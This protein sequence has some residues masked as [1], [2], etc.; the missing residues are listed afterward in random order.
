M[1]MRD[2][3]LQRGRELCWHPE[4]MRARFE[5]WVEGLTGDWNI[6]RQRS[7]GCRSRSGTGSTTPARRSRG[8]AHRRAR[9]AAGRPLDRRPTGW[10]ESQRG[11]PG[12]FVGDADIMD[13]WATSS[14]SPQ[15]AGGWID[16][17]DL[18]GRVFPMDLRPQAHDII[19]TWLFTTIVRAE[20][21]QQ[22]LPWQHAAISGWIL[23]PDRKKLSKSKGNA[24][25]VPSEPLEHYGTDAVRYWAAS[26]RLGVDTAYDE[27]Q[28]KVGRRLAIKMLNVSRFVLSLSEEPSPSQPG[29]GSPGVVSEA[30]D[31]ALLASLA[32]VVTEATQAFERF[33]HSRSLELLEGFFW[34]Y[35]DDYVE[36]V[37]AR[38]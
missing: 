36:L 5:S 13:T 10:D 2:R 31:A 14:L 18:F 11:R 12:G 22:Q 21:E 30:L 16:D 38:A 28:M 3:L 29:A 15:I 24:A 20:L 26:A 34:S 27:Q 4:F 37:K 17:P 23:D 19:R 35:C 33:D 7:S 32:G 8:A 9:K 25:F 6:S 1:A